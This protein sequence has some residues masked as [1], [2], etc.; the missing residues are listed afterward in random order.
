MKLGIFAKTFVRPTVEATLEAIAE[1]GL[2]EVQFNLSCCGL[3]TVPETVPASLVR[4]VRQAFERRGLAMAALSATFNLIHPNPEE[5]A[6]GL[7]RL[8]GLTRVAGDLGTGLLTLCTGSRDAANM[9]RAHAENTTESA[10]EDL[11]RSMETALTSAAR[12][13]VVLGVEPELSNVIDSAAR[14]RQLLGHFRSPHLKIVIDP[15]NLFPAGTLPQMT[16]I[17]NEAFD[18]LSGDVVLAHAKDLRR[19]GGA[20]DQAAGTGVLDYDL[21]LDRLRAAGYG[22]ALI[23]HGLTEA[24]VQDSVRFLRGKVEPRWRPGN[25]TIATS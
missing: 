19:D 1:H 15:A 9:W 7:S 23:L 16:A 13:N 17:L 24:Q 6:S 8:D 11:L 5:R 10:W 12:A 21:Y 20:G 14:A 25:R 4:D 3:P 18:L 22:G 2:T